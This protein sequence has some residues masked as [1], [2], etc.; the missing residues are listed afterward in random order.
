MVFA[1]GNWRVCWWAMSRA[2]LGAVAHE[3]M[4]VEQRAV[5]LEELHAAD[6]VLTSG[7]A[8]GLV[9]IVAIDDRP[10]GDGT[11]GPHARALFAALAAHVDAYVVARR[12][13]AVKGA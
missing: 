1:S 5:T 2:P 11:V 6:E 12:G 4:P 3:R 10:V 7:A 9:P 13:G 8:R